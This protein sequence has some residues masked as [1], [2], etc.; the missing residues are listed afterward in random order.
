MVLG[1]LK[2]QRGP[3]ECG[4]RYVACAV[5]QV[6]IPALHPSGAGE[7]S[8]VAP[9]GFPASP[10][11]SSAVPVPQRRTMAAQPLLLHDS[12][13]VP[14][15]LARNCSDSLLAVFGETVPKGH[16]WPLSVR[17]Q[18]HFWPCDRTG[19]G[20]DLRISSGDHKPFGIHG[21]S[22]TDWEEEPDR[23][24]GLASA[25]DRHFGQHSRPRRGHLQRGT[26]LP[27][28]GRRAHA[29]LH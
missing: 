13:V 7:T 18:R 23:P 25:G 27:P 24:R 14:E 17:L 15:G 12:A 6:S 4:L 16:P 8:N 29:R 9:A 21:D 1:H 10:G 11:T 3:L 5:T 22:R 2:M 26:V 28:L 20:R 19:T